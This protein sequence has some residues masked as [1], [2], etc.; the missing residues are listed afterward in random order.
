MRRAALVVFL[1][2]LT[3]DV[4]DLSSLVG[5]TSCDESCPTDLPGGQCPP[6]CHSCSCCSLPQV[7]PSAIVALVAPL[8]RAT[9]WVRSSADVVAPEPADILHVPKP[10][11]A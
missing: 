4:S 8:A 6:N 9:S 11:L 5:E 10:L 1:A 3:F 7:T 2:L